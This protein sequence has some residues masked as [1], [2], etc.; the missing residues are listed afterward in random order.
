MG[1]AQYRAGR[2]A[3]AEARL[4]RNDARFPGWRGEVLD[5]LV[6]A[7]A[8]QKLGRNHAAR[9]SLMQADQ[10]IAARLRDRP[11]GLDRATPENWPWRDG[12]LMHLLR[13]EAHAL[14]DAGLANLPADAFA[15]PH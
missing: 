5:R 15:P 3:E 4:M 6:V 11:G 12:I 7:M 9:R 10:W 8:Q 13:E 14:V 1:L 2:F